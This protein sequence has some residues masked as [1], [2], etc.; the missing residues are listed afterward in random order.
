M[1]FMQVPVVGPDV[2]GASHGNQPLF[3]LP[4]LSRSVWLVTSVSLYQ[5]TRSDAGIGVDP[6]VEPGG[7]MIAAV[8][9][10]TAPSIATTS[11]S[12]ATAPAT[13]RASLSFFIV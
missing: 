3:P 10:C 9:P 1:P 5:A 11:P 7:G 6:V 12:A 4:E 13:F 2:V 8:A